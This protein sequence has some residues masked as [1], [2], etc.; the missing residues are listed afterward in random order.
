MASAP[1]LSGGVGPS[2]LAIQSTHRAGSERIMNPGKTSLAYTFSQ[3][4]P[5]GRAEMASR[6]S[7]YIRA[8]EVISQR[9]EVIERGWRVEG[10]WPA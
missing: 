8:E 2:S 3:L 7:G 9:A 10:L 4:C 1:R 5:E 6:C